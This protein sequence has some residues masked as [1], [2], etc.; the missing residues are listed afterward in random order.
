M[1]SSTLSLTSA[2]DGVGGQRH[3]LPLYSR[4][5]EPVPIVQEAGWAPEPVWVG[6]EDIGR[7]G[8]RSPN[9][10]MANVNAP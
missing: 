6:A 2:P 9:R 10:P 4:E 7:A 8:I 5:R 3:A 1:Y